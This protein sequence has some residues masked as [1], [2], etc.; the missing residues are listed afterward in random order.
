VLALPDG[1]ARLD[2]IDE[3][4]AGKKSFLAMHRARRTNDGCLTDAQSPDAVLRSEQDV[5]HLTF[6]FEHNASHFGDCHGSIRL[7]L[8]HDHRAAF[9]ASPHN[10]DKDAQTSCARM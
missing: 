8:K 3:R 5:R 6:N 1:H 4:P 7:V 10:A 9:A 2:P